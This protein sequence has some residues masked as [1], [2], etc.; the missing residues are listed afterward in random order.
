MLQFRYKKVYIF[1]VLVKIY[2]DLPKHKE[3]KRVAKHNPILAS[4]AIHPQ[5]KND[6]YNSDFHKM[7]M[8]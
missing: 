2:T 8:N 1:Y 6:K 7:L 3:K 5:D 4:L